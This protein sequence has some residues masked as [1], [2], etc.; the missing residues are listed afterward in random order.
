MGASP[1]SALAA[2]AWPLPDAAPTSSVGVLV[3]A[4]LVVALAHAVWTD[5]RT[6]RISNRLTYPLMLAG[7]A[8][9]GVAAGQAGLAGSAAGLLLGGAL[10]LIPC[11]LGAMGIGDAKLLAAIGALKGPFF[12]LNTVV[13]AGLA[14]GLLALLY[15][16]KDERVLTRWRQWR[17][18]TQRLLSEGPEAGA[19]VVSLRKAS[20]PYAPA[21]AVGALFAL[22]AYT[23]G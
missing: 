13:Y 19:G 11:A 5:I 8:I 4:L 23:L 15:L 6:R 12:A 20:M 9:N 17:G 2:L 14:G 1:L 21:I 10:L 7:L 16:A 3:N 22:T 18:G